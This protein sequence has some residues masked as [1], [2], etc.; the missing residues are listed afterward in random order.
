MK[1][2]EYKRRTRMAWFEHDT[3]RIYYEDQGEGKPVLLLPGFA[4]NIGEF[5]A[6]TDA[7]VSA[8]YRVIAAD[9]PGSGQSEP[10][11]RRYTAAYYEEDARAFAEL[12]QHLNVSSAHLMGFSDGGEVALLMATQMP[13]LVRSLLTWGAAGKISDPDGQLRAAMRKVIDSPI[14]PM[15]PF[16]DY[17]IAAYGVSNARAMTQS[18]VDAVDNIID[19]GGDISAAKSNAITCPVLLIAGEHDFVA[20]PALV[21]DLAAR[22]PQA[23]FIKVEGAGHDVHDSHAKW[24]IRTILDWLTGH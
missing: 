6:L 7:L 12:L 2:N 11:P 13:V 8:K 14:P 16:R 17:L 5:S 18:F 23:K 4:G 1:I 19:A 21:S 24:L 20:S 22:I 15:Q 3:S 9:L 10:Q